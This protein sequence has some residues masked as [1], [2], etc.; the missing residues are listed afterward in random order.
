[1]ENIKILNH[2]TLK[3]HFIAMIIPKNYNVQN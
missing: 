3:F 1:M 2:I